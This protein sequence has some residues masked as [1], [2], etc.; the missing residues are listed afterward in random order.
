MQEGKIYQAVSGTFVVE[1]GEKKLYKASVPVL[2]WGNK[3][4]VVYY[5]EMIIDALYRAVSPTHVQLAVLKDMRKPEWT[6]FRLNS[7]EEIRRELQKGEK[8]VYQHGESF[9]H[10]I[11]WSEISENDTLGLSDSDDYED[12]HNSGRDVIHITYQGYSHVTSSYSSCEEKGIFAR[13][14]GHEHV[15][16]VY[17]K[18]LAMPPFIE[19]KEKKGYIKVGGQKMTEEQLQ[20][21]L[22]IK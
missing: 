22:Q 14:Y 9:G 15:I 7:F 2:Y 5:E 11:S 12:T 20:K 21:F 17:A 1:L 4:P 8:L 10:G 6:Y 19:V 18:K 13:R 3:N 16:R